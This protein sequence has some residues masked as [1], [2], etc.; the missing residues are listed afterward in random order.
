MKVEFTDR[1][2]AL[3][4][5]LIVPRLQTVFLKTNTGAH[6]PWR[7]KNHQTGKST[8]ITTTD[9]AFQTGLKDKDFQKNTH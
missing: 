8:V 5:T 1:K 7:C 3:L 2:G 6:T 4:K 9:L